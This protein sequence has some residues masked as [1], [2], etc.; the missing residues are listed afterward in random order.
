MPWGGAE[1]FD[2][3]GRQS[4]L[5][6]FQAS[7]PATSHDRKYEP[8]NR[9]FPITYTVLAVALTISVGCRPQQPFYFFED[10]DLSHYVDV[11]TEIDYPDVESDALCEVEEAMPPLSLSNSEPREVWDLSLEETMHYALNN[12]KVIR[13][14]GAQISDAPDGLM[15]SP[16]TV[17]TVYD[18]ALS[19]ANPRFGVEA[20]LSAFDT[21]FS[22]NVFWELK[23]TPINNIQGAPTVF[24]V[25]DR[26]DL[27]TFQA[28]LKKT[29]AT[30]GTWAIRQ[31]TSYDKRNTSRKFS[32]S[33]NVNIETEF[34]QPL[35][36]GA[37]VQFNRIAG[38]GAI[39]GFNNGVIIA[40]I[41]T[42]IALTNFEARVRDLVNEVE[43][44][45]WALYLAYR[46]LDAVIAG[47][48]SAL[49]TWRKIHAL[50][51]VSARGGEAEK[52]AQ[53]REQY[54]L[55]RSQVEQRLNNLYS[56]ENN[57][58]Y[59]IGLAAT[60]GRLIRPSDEPTSAKVTFDWY[61]AHA[62]ALVRNVDVRVQKWK[63][64]RSEMELIAA[65]NYL[66]P[67]LDAIGVYRWLGMGDDLINANRQVQPDGNAFQSLTSG[68][69]QE[70]Q[71][72]LD[73][74][75]PIGFR[76][77]MAGVRYA[78]LN[79]ARQR[80]VLQEEEL[81]LSHQLSHAIRSVES[82]L[83]ITHTNFNRR[84]AAQRQVEAV[85]AAYET[86]TV[87]LDLLLETQRRLAEAEIAYFRSLVEY[88]DAIVEV[89]YRK[90]SL[91]EY[92]DIFLAEGPWP[93]KAYFD[94]RRLARARDASFYLD[95]GF[96]RPNVISRGSIDQRIGDD[97]LYHG[98]QDQQPTGTVFEEIPTP[99]P[100]SLKQSPISEEE[101][102][103]ERMP[104]PPKADGALN[105]RRSFDGVD[106][107]GVVSKTKTKNRNFKT[108]GQTEAFD[109]ANLDLSTLAGGSV[110]KKSDK[111]QKSGVCQV[112]FQETAISKENTNNK[113]VRSK[114]SGSG[115]ESVKNTATAEVNQSTSS[116]KRVQR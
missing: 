5:D 103:V 89:H 33:W 21:E 58:R 104:L 72:G 65:K 15:R 60:D 100:T 32:S 109:F 80:A 22:S 24:P 53:A 113:W 59:I 39:P 34:R 28:Q 44:A 97:Q 71:F 19:E 29:A 73:L 11:A 91:L 37:G 76:K 56:V 108:S 107:F 88:N 30:G 64:K 74:S 48:D 35:L 90:G 49:Q 13:S 77:E 112:G 105:G 4:H 27:G 45:Y 14:L 62:E 79:L 78:Q 96:T 17:A 55:F 110:E 75:I 114:G 86:E 83:I 116:W 41:N 40:R 85:A 69:Y 18:P 38:P 102:S 31:N 46:E 3:P 115:H 106:L 70:W 66:L 82:D 101:V 93:G 10:G 2:P 92:N 8:M 25:V 52:E 6:R 7:S 9:R 87:T 36:Q 1:L 51:V 20:A 68:K 50:Y 94:A 67:R 111:T 47:R 42:D 61:E 12:S 99:G 95:Y 16:D 26:Q 43:D 63:V 81:E 54:F 23:D 98:A 84:V 57:L